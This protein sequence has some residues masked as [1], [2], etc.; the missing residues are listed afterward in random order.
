MTVL[1]EL[2][3]KFS[4]LNCLERY[5]VSCGKRGYKIDSVLVLAFRLQLEADRIKTAFEGRCSE[6]RLSDSLNI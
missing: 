4:Y 1:M 3:F 2:S 5:F 6:G